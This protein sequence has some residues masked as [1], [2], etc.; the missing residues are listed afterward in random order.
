MI[1]EFQETSS[2]TAVPNTFIDEYMGAANGEY[3]KVYIYL[4]RLAGGSREDASISVLADRLELTEKDVMR[5]LRYWEKQ[6]LLRL[7]TRDDRVTGLQM[8]PLGGE[9]DKA[10]EEP[11]PAPEPAPEPEGK[12]EGVPALSGEAMER[13]GESAEFKQLLYVAEKYL[14]RPLSQK[15]V[16]LFAWL[17]DQLHF[18]GDLVEYLLEYCAGSG[19]NSTR[20]MEKVAMGWHQEGITSVQQIREQ[21]RD[22]TRENREIM[23]AF[24]ISGRVLTSEERRAVE[25]WRKE[26]RMPLGVIVEACGAT[27][28]S[29]HQPSFEYT[30]SILKDW[31]D[32]GISTVEEAKAHQEQR[33]I[34]RK[35]QSAGEKKETPRRSRFVNYDQRDMDYDALLAK[36]DWR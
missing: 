35:S 17:L 26:Y 1:I 19:H 13:L 8:L 4:L 2:L 31:R 6:K 9:A 15:D 12:P 24:G 29:I 22:Y 23:K 11:A 7:E 28:R 20:Y 18:P 10:P 36:G 30:E 25:R 3:V 32:A 34:R 27:M 21:K 5:A 16:E 14:A 33:R